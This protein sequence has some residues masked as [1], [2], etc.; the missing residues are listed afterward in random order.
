MYYCDIATQDYE[1]MLAA[2]K[3]ELQ[4]QEQIAEHWRKMCH[5]RDKQIL[6]FRSEQVLEKCE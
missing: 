5:A 2:S 6:R 1:A 4:Q 3:R